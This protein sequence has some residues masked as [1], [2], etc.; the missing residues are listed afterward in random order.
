MTGCKAPPAA[1]ARSA[2]RQRCSDFVAFFDGWV[3]VEISP[4]KAAIMAAHC[5]G[6]TLGGFVLISGQAI[7]ESPYPTEG[8]ASAARAVTQFLFAGCV[9]SY[10]TVHLGFALVGRELGTP[11]LMW[12]AASVAVA[13]PLVT[14]LPF[15]I[16]SLCIAS[17]GLGLL[18]ARIHLGRAAVLSGG[19]EAL[20]EWPGFSRV[21][22]CR[23]WC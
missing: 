18:A 10:T 9:V 15:P 19:F 2:R 16:V 3:S 20:A 11:S 23:L 4:D 8:M 13:A 1:E 5:F 6:Y 7:F 22:Q 14:V 17:L 21:P 12:G